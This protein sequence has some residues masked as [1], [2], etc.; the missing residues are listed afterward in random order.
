MF[1]SLY[2]RIERITVNILLLVSILSRNVKRLF[3]CIETRLRYTNHSG[4]ESLSRCFSE[5]FL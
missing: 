5:M 4:I 1:K 2:E 3:Y